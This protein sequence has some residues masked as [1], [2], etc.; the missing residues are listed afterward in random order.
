MR[1][2]AILAAGLVVVALGACSHSPLRGTVADK[3]FVPAHEGTITGVVG[4]TPI[5]TT[6]ESCSSTG[7]TVSCY[8]SVHTILVP[9]YGPVA[10][11]F[12]DAWTLRVVDQHRHPHTVNVSP[13]VFSDTAIGS[14]WVGR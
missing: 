5:I 8:P 2:L 14:L 1:R 13:Q 3:D 10:H 11:H 6:T 12:G 9:I 4:W 7:K